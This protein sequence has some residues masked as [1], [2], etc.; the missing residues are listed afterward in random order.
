MCDESFVMVLVDYG[1][2]DC[3]RLTQMFLTT[4]YSLLMNIQKC[5]VPLVQAEH[6]VVVFR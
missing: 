4:N 5:S 2:R 6:W 3:I 1:L